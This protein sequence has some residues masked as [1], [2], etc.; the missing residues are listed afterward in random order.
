M[1][2]VCVPILVETIDGALLD[3]RAARDAGADL[4]EFRLDSYYTG[5]DDAAQVPEIVRL[6]SRSA[7]PCIA[8]CRPVLEG[9]HYDGPDDARIALFERLGNAHGPGQTPPRY[10]DVELSTFQRSANLRQKVMLAVD[11]GG[12]GRADGSSLILST[13]D[14][15][16][17]PPDLIRRIEAMNSSEP[18]RVMKVA[19]RARSLRDNLE[20]LELLAESRAGEGGVVKPMIAL[21]MG[22]F[23]LMSRVLAPKFGAFLTFASLRRDSATAPGQPVIGE[24]LDLYRLRSI[25]S[26]TRVYGVIGWPVERSLSPLVHNAAFEAVGHDG[27][28]LPLPVAPEWEQFKATVGELADHAHLDLWGASVTL[29]HKQHLVRMALERRAEG[30]ERWTLDAVSEISGAGNTLSV[31]RDGKGRAVRLAV[32]NTDGPAAEALLTEALG[33][34]SGRRI[35]V[36][37]AGGTA[38]AVATQLALAGANVTVANRT[39]ERASALA[40]E[41]SARVPVP[42]EAAGLA[43]APLDGAQAV[44]QATAAGMEGGP[45]AGQSPLSEAQVRNLPAGCVVA[46]C[47]YRPPVT[48]LMNLAAARGLRVI[49]GAALFVRQAAE[50]STAWTH[51]PAPTRLFERIVRESLAPERPGA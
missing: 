2:L 34:L 3:A 22:P 8:T 13:H 27:V 33:P 32:S 29:P 19:Y 38:R 7:V 23:G 9:G 1:T 26:A 6:V 37:G 35:V 40:S 4:V 48:P 43:D 16:T 44:V 30:D 20:L 49:D 31:Q 5:T 41:I 28:Y 39:A 17:R 18:A 45:A 21:A 51:Q 46:E 10:I 42:I 50:Q 14:F 36:L 24:L 11:H 12:G 15:H 25:G 47:V